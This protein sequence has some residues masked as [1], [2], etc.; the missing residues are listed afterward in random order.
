MVT[1]TASYD[2]QLRCTATH[3]PSGTKL[4]TDATR[5]DNHGLGLSFSADR[6]R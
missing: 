3:G 6:P 5:R 4:S 1:I 2:G